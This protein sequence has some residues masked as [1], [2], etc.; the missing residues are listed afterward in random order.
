MHDCSAAAVALAW[1][2][3]SGNVIAIPESGSPAHVKENAV[4]L[5]VALTPGDLRTLDAAYPGSFGAS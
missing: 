4:A 3:R 2:I 1:V 5:S